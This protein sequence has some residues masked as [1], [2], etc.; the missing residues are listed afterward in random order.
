MEQ[1]VPVRVWPRAPNSFCE[2]G[3]RCPPFSI[4]P[5]NGALP[6]LSIPPAAGRQN[7]SANSEMPGMRKRWPLTAF[8]IPRMATTTQASQTRLWTM[9]KKG[10]M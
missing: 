9:K 8:T 10:I 3:G 5:L 4:T 2:K 1:S 7:L 6:P